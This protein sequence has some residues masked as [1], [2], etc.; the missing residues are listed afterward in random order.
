MGL[1]RWD[2]VRDRAAAWAVPAALA[3]AAVLAALPGQM[4][5]SGLRYERSEIAGGEPWR[6]VSG[7]IVH[8]DGA[9]LLLNLAGLVLIWVLVGRAFRPLE[10]TIVLFA[11]VAVID[12]AFWWLLPGL[13]WYVG[14]SGALHGLFAAGLVGNASRHPVES[15]LLG[16]VLL[17]K[18]GWE[19]FGGSLPGTSEFVTGD[20]VTEAHFFGAV[21][22][23]LA[24]LA[25]VCLRTIRPSGADTI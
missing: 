21:G 22:G 23:L 8:L 9:H 10:W 11:S 24:A 1:R 14:L 7:H 6:L 3:G 25:L 4:A 5:R 20:V 18:L 13:E 16:C 12:A 15:G 19:Q 17:A 2:P